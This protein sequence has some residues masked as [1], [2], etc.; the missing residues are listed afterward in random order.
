MKIFLITLFIYF[1]VPFLK[2]TYLS[3]QPSSGPAHNM[4]LHL[5]FL[6]FPCSQP[7]RQKINTLKTLLELNTI[8][9]PQPFL[10]SFFLFP[11]FPFLKGTMVTSISATCEFRNEGFCNFDNGGPAFTA[12]T[13][14]TLVA[15]S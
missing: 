10:L 15:F 4:M 12:L 1:T 14:Q 6:M 13:V 2:Q 11:F 3:G 7:C 9:F 8:W 5:I